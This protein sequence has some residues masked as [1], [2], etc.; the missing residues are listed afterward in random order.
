MAPWR[1]FAR[2]HADSLSSHLL[3]PGLIRIIIPWTCLGIGRADELAALP[4]ESGNEV[5]EWLWQDTR[6]DLNELK[7]RIGAPYSGRVLNN[8]L[9]PLIGNRVIYPEGTVNSFVERYLRERVLK[10]FETKSRGS[11]GRQE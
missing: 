1:S 9:K 10:L 11:V 4:G 5:W 7:E 3:C 6:F 8:K 2:S